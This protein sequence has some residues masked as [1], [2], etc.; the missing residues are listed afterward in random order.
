[1]AAFFSS[2]LSLTKRKAS[3][4]S[5][6]VFFDFFSLPNQKKNFLFCPWFKRLIALGSF[7]AANI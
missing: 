3:S 4:A 5:P 7:L 6:G 2:S 1:L